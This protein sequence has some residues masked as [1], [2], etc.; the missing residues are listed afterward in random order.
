MLKI[1][2]GSANFLCKEPDGN[3][4]RLYE[5]DGVCMTQLGSCSMKGD[6]CCV[7]KQVWPC[8]SNF[9]QPLLLYECPNNHIV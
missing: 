6:R 7:D 8:A 4:I 5:L 3:Y 2:Q 1:T 9:G